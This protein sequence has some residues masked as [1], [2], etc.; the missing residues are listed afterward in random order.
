MQPAIEIEA[1][2]KYYARGKQASPALRGVSLVVPAGV[3]FGVVGPN[4]AGK[5]T[6]FKIIT[7]LVLAAEGKVRVLSGE[8][9][10]PVVQRRL[11]YCTE[12][13]Q[14]N[15][16]LTVQE[17]IGF[18]GRFLGMPAAELTKRVAVLD[19]QLDVQILFNKVIRT[20]SKGQKQRVNLLQSLLGDPDLLMLDEPFNGLDPTAQKSLREIIR[21]HAERGKT[22]LINSHQLAEVEL[23]SDQVAMISGGQIVSLLEVAAQRQRWAQILFSVPDEVDATDLTKG[24]MA[25]PGGRLRQQVAQSEL[26]GW[27]AR[28]MQLGGTLHTVQEG[29]QHLEEVYEEKLQAR[30]G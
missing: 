21:E 29:G 23:L 15:E 9:G 28:L 10:S 26:N 4:G 5:S 20:L 1:V 12:V 2:T 22:V 17:Y 8:P 25:L 19:R 6:L 18:C 16:H 24:A 14:L 3:V 30:R 11:G 13:P 7:G 27:L